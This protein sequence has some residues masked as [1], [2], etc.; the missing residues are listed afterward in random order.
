[1]LV[2][3]NPDISSYREDY[4]KWKQKAKIFMNDIRNEKKTYEDFDKWLDKNK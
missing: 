1:M 2:K 3:R 4:E